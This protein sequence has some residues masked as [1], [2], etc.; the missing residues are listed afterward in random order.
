[1]IY[2]IKNREIVVVLSLFSLFDLIWKL[3]HFYVLIVLSTV[4]LVIICLF[5]SNG[6]I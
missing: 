5:G 6:I 4:L 2:F 3:F 1:M